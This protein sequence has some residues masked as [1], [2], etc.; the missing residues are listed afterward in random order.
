MESKDLRIGNLIF[1]EKKIVE[2]NYLN[3]YSIG[4]GDGNFAPNKFDF[5]APIPLTKEWLL[6]LGFKEYDE[7]LMFSIIAGNYYDC[8]NNLKIKHLK[9]KFTDANNWRIENFGNK[10]VYVNYV[11]QLQNLYF[12]IM[13]VD[14]NC[15]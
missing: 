8:R 4:W 9:I 12:A 3:P 6:K 7:T 2:V 11:H 15:L 1:A 14:L 10:M 13:N 5:F